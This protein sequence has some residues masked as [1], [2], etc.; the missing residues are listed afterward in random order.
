MLLFSYGD[1]VEISYCNDCCD[2]DYCNI[3]FCGIFK[4]GNFNGDDINVFVKVFG[5]NFG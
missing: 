5:F 3:G 2:D 1:L 4:W